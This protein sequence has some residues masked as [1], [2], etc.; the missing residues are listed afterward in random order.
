MNKLR[1]GI[2][3]YG[4]LGKGL[5]DNIGLTKDIECVGIFTRRNPK[6]IESEIPVYSY[7]EILSFKDKIDFI[8]LCGGSQKDI[9]IQGPE[10]LENFN[11][12]DAYDNHQEIPKYLEKMNKIALEN[13]K[14]AII[15]GGWDPGLFSLNRLIFSS[16]MPYGDLYTFWGNGVSQGHSDVLRRLDGVKKAVQYTLPNQ[17]IMNEIKEGKKQES[18]GKRCHK[19]VCYIVPNENC[20]KESLREEIC[21][22]PSYFEGYEVEVNYISEEEF[23]K[24]HQKMNHGGFVLNSSSLNDN[25]QLMEFSLKLDS[26]P[27]FTSAVLLAMS[28]AISVLSRKKD[29]GAFTIFDIP[30]IYYSGEDRMENI[31]KLL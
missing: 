22:M 18:L 19:R 21:K 1:V 28:R 2:V 29:Y 25:H 13:R 14:V 10:V 7:D 11:T 12:I 5:I 6:D 16:I 9:P 17:D 8:F 31:R 15:A 23:S 4:N 26:N 3:G 24:N 30:P 20:D 27:L